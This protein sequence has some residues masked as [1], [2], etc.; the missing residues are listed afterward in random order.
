MPAKGRS[1][2]LGSVFLLAA[3]A[4]GCLAQAAQQP[5][6][7]AGPAR[8]RSIPY[9]GAFLGDVTE[10][11]LTE[12]KLTEIRGAVVGR[13]VED[14]P[15]AKAGIKVGDVLLT[16]RG[17][18]IEGREHF[19]RLLVAYSPGRMVTLG[20]SRD[21]VKQN[22]HVALAERRGAVDEVER[23]FSEP[24]EIRRAGEQIALDAQEARQKGDEKGAAELESRS[25]AL[26]KQAEEGRA[27]IEKRLAAG[28]GTAGP[29]SQ[30]SYS[31]NANRHLLGVTV[32]PLSPQLAGYF[33]VVGGSGVL[34][35]EV[36]SGGLIERAG[37]KVGDCITGLN[38]EKVSSL[39]D[40]TRQIGLASRVTSASEVT[41]S[42]VRDRAE[43]TLKITLGAR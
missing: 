19:Y 32:K 40:L 33:G 39:Q 15:A 10:D 6:A 35:T 18:A 3:L 24:E 34:V 31:L 26:L 29:G 27:E 25:A 37:I 2:L 43:S 41:F 11:R 38:G 8:G 4:I 28:G 42:V 17:D 36:R 5:T 9:L 13:V 22:I 21:G 23:L 12:L 20:I 14:S 30:S 7:S 16:F 1:R